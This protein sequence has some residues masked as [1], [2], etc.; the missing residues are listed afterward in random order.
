MAGDEAEE[1]EKGVDEAG[2]GLVGKGL[3]TYSTI[4]EKGKGW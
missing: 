2:D 3:V 4:G 1:T